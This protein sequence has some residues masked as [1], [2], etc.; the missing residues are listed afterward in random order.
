MEKAND[1]ALTKLAVVKYLIQENHY[2]QHEITKKA[3]ISQA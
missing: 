1:I 3:N 2:T